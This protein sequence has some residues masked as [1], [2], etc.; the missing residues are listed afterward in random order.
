M[1]AVLLILGSMVLVPGLIFALIIAF[2][3]IGKSESKKHSIVV[4]IVLIVVGIV[5]VVL[6]FTL[7]QAP[8]PSLDELQDDGR[9]T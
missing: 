1:K 3:N 4:P 7:K 5:S 8:P 6:G 9:A 2:D